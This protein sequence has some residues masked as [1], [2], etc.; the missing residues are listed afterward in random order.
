[1]KKESLEEGTGVKSLLVVELK[2]NK[3]MWWQVEKL[4]N[5]CK[6]YCEVR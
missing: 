5:R 6:K 3:G 1:M 2:S 4:G